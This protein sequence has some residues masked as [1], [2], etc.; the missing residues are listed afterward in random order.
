M[1]FIITSTKMVREAGY[2]A[3][4]LY[5]IIHYFFRFVKGVYN[6][7]TITTPVFIIIPQPRLRVPEILSLEPELD[8]M[9]S[10]GPGL[11]GVS[12]TE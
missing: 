6:F 4:I 2:P 10:D 7:F 9:G 8:V 11:I 12:V 3:K 1:F 5:G